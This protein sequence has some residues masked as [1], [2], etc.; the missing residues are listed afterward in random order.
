MSD[1]ADHAS[2]RLAVLLMLVFAAACT[3][4][5][6]DVER[7][8]ARVRAMAAIDPNAEPA[9]PKDPPSDGVPEL[10]TEYWLGSQVAEEERVLE[11]GRQIQALQQQVAQ[12][13]NTE[14]MR[15]FHAKAH[16]C[17]HGELTL[18][19][20]RDARTRFGIF[21]GDAPLPV[22]VRYSNGVGWKQGDDEL[23][24]RGMAVKVL[25]VPGEK[26]LA[27]EP[28]SQ[29][30]LMTNSPIPVGKDAEE[31]MQFAHA[32]VKGRVAGL[33]FLLGH[34]RTGAALT[35]TGA[36]SSAVSTTYWS[37]GPYHLGAHQAIKYL[38][39][40]CAGSPE[41]PAREGPDRL[42]SDLV[43]AAQQG[44]CYTLFVQ[45][46]FDAVETPIENA[47]VPWDEELS[48]PVP[49]ANIVMP[50]Q[51]LASAEQCDGLVMN[52]WHAIAAHKPMGSHNRARRI[53]YAAS[54][55]LRARGAPPE[56]WQA[57]AAP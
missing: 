22:W 42:K 4:H 8:E 43:D 39:K 3:H 34:P 38:S 23:D 21:A 30:F 9:P 54:A 33:F 52:P 40:P 7:Q 47:S 48:V 37:G 49:V 36:I 55:K 17:L 57:P 26:Y 56:P 19:P 6:T 53:V 50:P 14:V 51:A 20:E 5:L 28:S 32:N 15:G 44:L 1:G 46:Q 41:R 35:K 31:F 25:G 16:G 12:K 13:R 10:N 11:F 27:D 45:F 18:N 29:D 24:A 2:S